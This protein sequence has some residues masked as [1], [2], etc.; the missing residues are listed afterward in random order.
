ME[1]TILDMVDLALSYVKELEM[2]KSFEKLKKAQ[3]DIMKKDAV[4]RCEKSAALIKFIRSVDVE[5]YKI[6]TCFA[7]YSSGYSEEERIVYEKVLRMFELQREQAVDE[8]QRLS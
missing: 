8:K 1:L 6:E 3:L 4:T 5:I 7:K 2:K